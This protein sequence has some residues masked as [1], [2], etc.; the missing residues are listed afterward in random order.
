MC[1][2]LKKKKVA[3]FQKQSSGQ[4]R[5]MINPIFTSR[6]DN[7][8]SVACYLAADTSSNNKKRRLQ[9]VSDMFVV[10][11]QETKMINYKLIVGNSF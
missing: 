8:Q 3:F 6:A 4:S 2:Y 10:H 5:E 1:R 11:V 7:D 9:L